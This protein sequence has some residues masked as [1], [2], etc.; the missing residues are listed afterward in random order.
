VIDFRYH[1]VSIVAVLFALA[2]GIVF[3]SGFLG[4]ALLDTLQNRLEAVDDE[5]RDLLRDV[6]RRNEALEAYAQ[7]AE[8]ARPWLLAGSL[9]GEEIVVV[10]VEGTDDSTMAGVSEAI[11]QAGASI[12]ATLTATERFE[13]ANAED[14]ELLRT[15]LGTGAR[16]SEELRRAAGGVL[17]ARIAAAAEL[18]PEPSPERPGLSST[19]EMRLEETV[20]ALAEQGFIGVER[21]RDDVTVPRGAVF[22]VVVGSPEAALFSA[23]G[24]VEELALTLSQQ[25]RTVVA[26]EPSA[27]VWGVVQSLCDGDAVDS[28]STV[29]HADTVPGQVAAV[30]G[31]DYART[32]GAGHWG[33]ASCAT[34][35]IPPPDQTG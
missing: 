6:A 33:T 34:E 10:T 9:V 7:F 32:N 22:V 12:P 3:G 4:G 31:L 35:V 26:A 23:R 13:L 30:L 21:A 24:L 20:D 8:Q 17:G 18:F 11:E 5:N 28:V 27:S 29:D 15:T 1:V 16:A 19:A 14:R 25:G 2:I